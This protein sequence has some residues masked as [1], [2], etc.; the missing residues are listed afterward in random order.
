MV[1][2][3]VYIWADADE[4]IG[5][6]H[7]IR[8]LAL[9][10]ML[11]DEFN[12]VYY[13]KTPTE[14]QKREVKQICSLRELPSGDIKYS[15]FLEEL[16]GDEIVVLDNYF[17]TSEFQKAVKDKGSKLI[18]FGSNDRHYYADILINF[19]NLQKQSFSAESYTR[20]CLGLQWALLRSEFYKKI[21]TS[22]NSKGILVCI[23]GTD[24]FCYAEKI[25]NHIRSSHPEHPIMIIATDRIGEQRIAEFK[26]NGYE[27]CLN[28]SARQM[29]EA[30]RKNKIAILSA[31]GV[32]IEALSQKCNVI[33]GYYVDNQIN[34]YKALTEDNY[35]WPV[36]D[37][38]DVDLLSSI[39]NAIG[40]IYEG[41]TKKSFETANTIELYQQLFRDL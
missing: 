16:S 21:T 23:G 19:T 36:G 10:D 13:T 30:F 41:K 8:C 31:S 37:F 40:Q 28:L 4:K 14:Y 38:S 9:V 25:S 7:F 26:N 29:A 17:F 5:Y 2:K 34:I 1:K 11:K 18:I 39:D 35:I 20:I 22:R 12:C 15:I 6:G 3:K 32:A 33:A 27:L 24:Q